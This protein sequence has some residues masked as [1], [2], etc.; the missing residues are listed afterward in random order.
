DA[1][2]Q[3]AF[4][5]SMARMVINQLP[6]APGYSGVVITHDIRRGAV[7]LP[8]RV[9][10]EEEI[11]AG[12][13]ASMAWQVEVDLGQATATRW[14]DQETRKDLKTVVAFAGGQM[15]AEPAH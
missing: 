9:T 7:P 8:F 4:D 11:T 12:G 3:G 13:K 10:A 5:Y 15:V 2:L 6:L 14:I 1:V